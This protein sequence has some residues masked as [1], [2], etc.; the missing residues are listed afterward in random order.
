MEVGSSEVFVAEYEVDPGR[1]KF[2]LERRGEL[3]VSPLVD[4][5]RLAV[6]ERNV[7]GLGS[8]KVADQFL[9]P[10]STR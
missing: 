8:R 5:L 3:F 4:Q 6:Y 9:R 2:L 1:S 10:C 7:L